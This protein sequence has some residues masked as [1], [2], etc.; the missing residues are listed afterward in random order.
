[1]SKRTT[2]PDGTPITCKFCRVPV[3]FDEGTGRIENLTGGFHSDAC[4]R[5]K[6]FYKNEAAQRVQGRR[7]AR[8]NG[9]AR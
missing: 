3:A 1:M 5:R 2:K 7:D 8:F 4:E 9:G 6:A